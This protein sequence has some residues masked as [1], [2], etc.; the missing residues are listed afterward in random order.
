[1]IDAQQQVERFRDFIAATYEKDF[2]E[3]IR[4][5]TK[6]L[7]VNF[8]EL[9][10][11]DAEL[12]DALL[13][14]PEELMKAADLSLT[15]FELPEKILVMVRWYNLSDSQRIKIKDIRSANLNYF[16]NSLSIYQLFTDEPEF[17]FS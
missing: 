9:L 16:D 13:D 10:S 17:S 15:H 6:S 8:S 7:L 4:K 11:F 3:L 14:E 2:H 5:G 12:A 1:M